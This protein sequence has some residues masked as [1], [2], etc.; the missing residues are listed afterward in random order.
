MPPHLVGCWAA[1]AHAL[2]KIGCSALPVPHSESASASAVY[3]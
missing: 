3:K 2:M 1:A